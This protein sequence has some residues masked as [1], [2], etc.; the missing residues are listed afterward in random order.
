MKYVI[1]DF[2]GT[3][4]FDS[5]IHTTVW[6]DMY[7][8]DVGGKPEDF[9]RVFA[10]VFVSNNLPIIKHF[11]KSLFYKVMMKRVVYS[12]YKW[13]LVYNAPLKEA[14]RYNANAFKP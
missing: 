12:L 1:F 3:L 10:E 2:N 5:D 11:Y 14:W 7:I 6:R 4:Y 9:D 13:T 8:N